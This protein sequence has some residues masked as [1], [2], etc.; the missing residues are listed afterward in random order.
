MW[1]AAGGKAG[2]VIEHRIRHRAVMRA[3]GHGPHLGQGI[4]V[5]IAEG[6]RHFACVERAKIARPGGRI[7]MVEDVEV[8]REAQRVL[9]LRDAL[10]RPAEDDVAR[11]IEQGVVAIAMRIDA[12]E[13]GRQRAIDALDHRLVLLRRWGHAEAEPAHGPIFVRVVAHDHGHAR[14]FAAVE[15]IVELIGQ[16]GPVDRTLRDESGQRRLVGE[17]LRV[18]RARR[19]DVGRAQLFEQVRPEP[20]GRGHAIGRLRQFRE[21]AQV[22][23][24]D[25][26]LVEQAPRLR[27]GHQV[28]RAERASGFAHHGDVPRIAAELCD[29]LAHPAQSGDLVEQPVV[30]R[31][32]VR[33]LLAQLLVRQPAERAEPVIERNEHH[34]PPRVIGAV[35]HRQAV[36]P[37][38]Q[39]TA[40]NP[41]DHGRV[42]RILRRPD[43]EIEA[44]FR[45][46]GGR[47]VVEA[48]S[49]NGRLDAGGTEAARIS[50]AIPP[51]GR[52]RRRPA[53]I[54]HRGRGVGNAAKDAQAVFRRPAK[55]AVRGGGHRRGR[56]AR[57]CGCPIVHARARAGKQGCRHQ[58]SRGYEPFHAFLTPL[59]AGVRRVCPARFA[60]A[61]SI[62]APGRAPPRIR[63]APLRP[64][65]RPG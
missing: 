5:Q 59:L 55:G 46:A 24:L 35:V 27:S 29:I 44:V 9:A 52:L 22:G 30:A 45:G 2:P 39:R 54:A 43:I 11:R 34:P 51:G 62:T 6:E 28:G 32:T 15:D 4:G 36:R 38:P 17:G 31:N 42:L 25:D 53:Q 8:G 63:P 10:S 40:V 49:R 56:N 23:A 7:A 41:D 50:Y 19:T 64:R 65:V 13:F 20:L 1:A 16:D 48:R 58:R 37:D 47:I 26:R 14:L 18:H 33:R 12:Q 57:P 21:A 61:C 60:P 3:V